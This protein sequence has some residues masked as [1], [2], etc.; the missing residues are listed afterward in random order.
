MSPAVACRGA[1]IIISQG[2][3][4][5]LSNS[6]WSREVRVFLE[7]WTDG[8]VNAACGTDRAALEERTL[9]LRRCGYEQTEVVARAYENAVDLPYIAGHLRSAMPESVLPHDREPEF[10]AGL[11]DA[12]YPH[13]ETGPLI[14][15]IEAT[16]LIAI[17]HPAPPAG[18]TPPKCRT[19]DLGAQR[20]PV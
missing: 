11:N 4:M 1:L 7:R 2:P 14:E 8:P 3:P 6:A 17:A 16:A 10:R 9:R 5:W 18:D 13:L 15:R 20:G 12:L 19:G